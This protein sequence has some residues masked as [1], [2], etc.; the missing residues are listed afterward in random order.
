MSKP[1]KQHYV[2][3]C[4]LREFIDPNTPVG[5]E[6]YIWR[7]EKNGKNRK[8]KS[9]SNIFTSTDL[10]TIKIAG[11]AKN[12]AIETTL[13]KIESKYA[14]IFRK[15]IK[16]KLPLSE[17]E[18]IV[19]SAFVATTIQRT[20]RRKDNLE[21]FFDELINHGEK[22]AQHHGIVSKNVE[23]LKK[24]K[25]NA[26][27]LSILEI[28]SEIT[29]LLIRMNVSFLC[30]GNSGAKF[31]TS[32]DPCILYNPKLQWQRFQGPGLE[33]RDI[34][35]ILPLSPEIMLCLSW[36]NFRGYIEM[37]KSKIDDLNRM[38]RAYCYKYFI[39]HTPKTKWIWFRK[40]PLNLFFLIKVS[41]N[42]IKNKIKRIIFKYKFRLC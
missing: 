35:V 5:Y 31:I 32:D 8:N 41:K 20:L 33:Q 19:L 40:Y 9:P 15:K 13:S 37:K 23:H 10:Y 11:R 21:Q 25:K 38:T 42:Q 1:K 26:H 14:N 17:Y 30:V 16:K 22:I 4:Y 2:T 24:Y 3:E 34:E 39:S 7:F 12:Y 29:Q 27:K 36:S 28:L 18:H 6:P